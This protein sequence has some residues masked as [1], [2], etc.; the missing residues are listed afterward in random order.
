MEISP[1]T[2]TIKFPSLVNTALFLR[3]PLASIL[4]SIPLQT[5][6]SSHLAEHVEAPDHMHDMQ[7]PTS[8]ITLRSN[9]YTPTESILILN[10]QPSQQAIFSYTSEIN[11]ISS[12]K[13]EQSSSPPF[14]PKSQTVPFSSS[15]QT[16]S[17]GPTTPNTPA[18]NN[19]SSSVYYTTC[20]ST[21]S[22]IDLDR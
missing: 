1:T 5:D 7:N 18:C 9:D 10:V 2:L 12:F 13:N 4:L 11:K 21:I 3:A 17:N 6:K 15:V 16:H 22:T 14:S 20:P 19:S 8:N